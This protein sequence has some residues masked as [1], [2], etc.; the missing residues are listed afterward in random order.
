MVKIDVR[1][2]STT[3]H[4]AEA[5]AVGCL[6]TCFHTQRYPICGISMRN[7]RWIRRLLPVQVRHSVLG[8]SL[9]VGAVRWG[10][11]DGLHLLRGRPRVC[12]DGRRHLLLTGDEMVHILHRDLGTCDAGKR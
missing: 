2:R 11:V 6:L 12:R 10:R 7:F 1:Y 8:T 9:S 5:A 4:N 3:L